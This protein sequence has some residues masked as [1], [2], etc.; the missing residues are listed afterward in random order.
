MPLAEVESK[1]H[2]LRICDFTLVL[3]I[4]ES[5]TYLASPLLP[6]YIPFSS[7]M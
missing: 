2:N 4:H 6:Q 7:F 1:S 5:G 3:Q